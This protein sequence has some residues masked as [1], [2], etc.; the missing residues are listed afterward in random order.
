MVPA[1]VTRG[2]GRASRLLVVLLL[3]SC[4]GCGGGDG[5]GGEGGRPTV[6][7]T[8]TPTATLP[9]LPS[10][11]RSPDLTER[12]EEPAAQPS[13]SPPAQEPTA[14]TPAPTAQETTGPADA[15]ADEPAQAS[16]EDEGVQAWVWWLLA[17]LVLGSLVGIPLIRR[18]RRRD[19]WRREVVEAEG[20]LAWCARELLPGLRRADSRA[21][22]S[23]GW[24]VGR[25]RVVA[26]EDRLTVLESTA[27]D[28]TDRQRARSLRDAARHARVNMERLIGPEPR[29]T[30]ALD[31]DVIIVDLEV[32]LRSPAVSSSG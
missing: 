7:P 30:W 3:I 20:E 9:E 5:G 29:D 14:E 18:A 28:E 15:P 11:T 4:G 12:P 17:A 1:R 16:G 2:T 31:L 6:S 8:R 26:V 10:P 23:G 27:P 32:A 24:A 19:A 13:S 21:Q 25:V 22:V